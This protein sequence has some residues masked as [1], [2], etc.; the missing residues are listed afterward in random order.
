MIDY[1]LIDDTYTVLRRH[2]ITMTAGWCVAFV[3]TILVK[4]MYVVYNRRMERRA[5]THDG[6]R[7]AE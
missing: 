2:Y 5:H 6:K 4:A 1:V 3:A 7:A